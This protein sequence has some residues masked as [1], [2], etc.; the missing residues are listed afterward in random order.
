MQTVPH[1]CSIPQVC[2]CIRTYRNARYKKCRRNNRPAKSDPIRQF[3]PCIHK[4]SKMS[5][6]IPKTIN[7]IFNIMLLSPLFCHN[8]CGRFLPR[9]ILNNSPWQK[10]CTSI[11]RST[12]RS[13]KY[14]TVKPKKL[15]MTSPAPYQISGSCFENSVPKN[16]PRQKADRR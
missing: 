6:K 2:G 8:F 9:F 11:W 10:I 7:I 12:Q 5:R 13:L 16:V 1:F 14:P 15:P 4:R 3:L